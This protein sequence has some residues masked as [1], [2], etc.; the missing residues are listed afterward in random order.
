MKKR[1]V[2]VLLAVVLPVSLL[3]GC[4]AERLS[5]EE[6][7]AETETA[8]KD[9]T[10]SVNDWAFYYAEYVMADGEEGEYA[11]FQENKDGIEQR[12]TIIGERL[13]AIEQIGNPP[14]E[15]DELHRRLMNDVKTDR[16]WLDHWFDAC[17]A[18]SE[19]EF[20]RATEKAAELVSATDD[21]LP[22]TYIEMYMRIKT[23]DSLNQ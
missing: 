8:F 16:K 11:L 21:T 18:D 3:C 19:A 9:Y 4:S 10:A 20:R 23:D 2:C 22:S 14:E 12:L 7:W 13:D 5:V 1:L 15:Y 17:S 6:Y